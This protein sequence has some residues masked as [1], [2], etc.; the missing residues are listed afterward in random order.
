MIQ[1]G[2]AVKLSLPPD[3]RSLFL[4]TCSDCTS[5][6]RS[7]LKRKHLTEWQVRKPAYKN[8]QAPKMA[9]C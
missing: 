9:T 1:T 2:K 3:D 5:R 8:Q 6:H 4:E 7:D